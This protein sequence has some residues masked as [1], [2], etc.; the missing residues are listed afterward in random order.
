MKFADHLT[1]QDIQKFNQ[2][3]KAE[4]NKG[5]P[6]AKQTTNKKS[7]EHLSYK[8]IENL[9]GIYQDTYVKKN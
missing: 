8:D 1:K 7:K 2:L 3:R 6:S 5:Q 9:M 4:R